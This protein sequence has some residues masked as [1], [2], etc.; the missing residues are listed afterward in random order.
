MLSRAASVHCKPPQPTFS[1]D[2]R[3]FGHKPRSHCSNC[4]TPFRATAKLGE[5]LAAVPASDQQARPDRRRIH[6]QSTTAFDRCSDLYFLVPSLCDQ[7][8]QPTTAQA[9]HRALFANKVLCPGAVYLLGALG[10]A[11]SV[12]GAVPTRAVAWRR[13]REIHAVAPTVVGDVDGRIAVA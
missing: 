13:K 6:I 5:F 2:C 3:A 9:I 12:R 10:P 8:H 1:V 4:T 11:T 7:Q